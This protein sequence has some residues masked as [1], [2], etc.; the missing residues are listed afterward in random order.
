MVLRL[1]VPGPEHLL[2]LAGFEDEIRAQQELARGRHDVLALLIFVDRV[3]EMVGLFEKHVR[4]A[5][6]RRAAGGAESGRPRPDYGNF[7]RRRH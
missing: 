5:E 1:L 7:E 3:G 6:L 4:E 2:A